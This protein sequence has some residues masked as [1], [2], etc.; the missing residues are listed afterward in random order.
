MDGSLVY[1]LIFMVSL[2]V[3]GAKLLTLTLSAQNKILIG[4]LASGYI[5][6]SLYFYVIWGHDQILGTLAVRSYFGQ[7]TLVIISFLT[8]VAYV[9]KFYDKALLYLSGL[10][11]IAG[12]AVMCF[13]IYKYVYAVNLQN[14]FDPDAFWRGTSILFIGFFL[15]W[16]LA[17][18]TSQNPRFKTTKSD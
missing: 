4:I 2:F 3:V 10:Y 13:M 9:K 1:W 18:R 6:T 16:H 14:D 17:Q 12:L 5:I 15:D 11:G 8:G 7:A